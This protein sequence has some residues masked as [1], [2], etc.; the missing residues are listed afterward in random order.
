M[1]KNKNSSEKPPGIIVI[2]PGPAQIGGVA[3]FIGILLSSS[4]LQGRYRFIH[5]DTTREVHDRG[6]AS[7]FSLI[8]IMYFLRQSILFLWIWSRQHPQI[9][10]VP[11]TSYWSFWKDAAFILLARTLG[12]KV[13]A[14]LHG[15]VF[16]RYYRESP[17]WT[18]RL[19]GWCMFKADVVIALSERWKEFLLNEVRHD[20]SIEVVPNTVDLMFA[21]AVHNNNDNPNHKEETVL[22]VGGLGHRK[23]VYDILKAIPLVIKQF[24]VVQFIFAGQEEIKGEWKKIEMVCAENDL[25]AHAQFPGFV[26]GQAKLELFSKATIFTLPSYGENLPF[27]VLE[28]MALGLP[29]ITTPVGAIPEIVEESQNGFLINPGDYEVLA[30]RI[31]KL[32]EDTSLR[33]MMYHANRKKIREHYLPEG[34][35]FKFD[36]VYSKLLALNRSNLL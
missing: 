14:H 36:A 26:T 29:I 5:L 12:I 33:A 16:D 17:A 18:Q 31:V 24:P 11:L 10:H 32:L 25:F 8:N 1:K 19:I 23:G 35:M 21:Q 28:A 22:F 9:M 27:S 15:G 7:R 20:L 13:V 34:A 6:T 2:G 3:T 4:Y 30:Q